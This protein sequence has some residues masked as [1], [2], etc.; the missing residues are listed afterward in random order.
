MNTSL[1]GEVGGG[2]LD[3]NRS[4]AE[5]WRMVRIFMG[6]NHY[7]QLGGRWG[8]NSFGL[9]KLNGYWFFINYLLF[10]N[11]LTVLFTTVGSSAGKES[12]CHAENPA[13]IPG[14]GSS[15]GKG[16]SYPLQYSWASLVAQTVKNPPAMWKT[17]VGKIPWR[18]EQLST[19]LLWPEEFHGQRSLADYSPRGPKESDTTERCPLKVFMNYIYLKFFT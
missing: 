6:Q 1:L 12:T 16:I 8:D 11:V 9:Q 3:R 10:F 17:W 13:S 19:L 4:E 7:N 2:S 5:S 18:R 14:L 15:P